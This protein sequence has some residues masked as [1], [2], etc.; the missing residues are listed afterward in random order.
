M[1]W[2]HHRLWSQ[3]FHCHFRSVASCSTRSVSDIEATRSPYSLAS[4]SLAMTDFIKFPFL[5]RDGDFKTW[6][7][8]MRAY[9]IT[10]KRLDKLLDKR[11]SSQRCAGARERHF[12]QST[13]A[14]TRC[15]AAQSH[16]RA[17]QDSKG[18][19]DYLAERVCRL[20]TNQTATTD[21]LPDRAKSRPNESCS[22]YRQ[23]QTAQGRV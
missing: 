7:S 12:V 21:G 9:L 16:R 15:R 6:D 1:S 17:I 14:T 20:V 3:V 10:Q 11:A 2:F 22:V 18:S 8:F 4:T 19:M 5:V 23:G 13:V